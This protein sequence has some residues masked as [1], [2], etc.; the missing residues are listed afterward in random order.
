ML[1]SALHILHSALVL[2]TQLLLNDFMHTFGVLS[3]A[4]VPHPDPDGRMVIVSGLEANLDRCHR[5]GGRRSL[6]Q[7]GL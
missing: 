1:H 5:P 3:I 6:H 4:K 7:G 2:H